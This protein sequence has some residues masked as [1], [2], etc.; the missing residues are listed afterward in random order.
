MPKRVAF[1]FVVYSAPIL[2]QAPS[3]HGDAFVMDGHIHLMTRQLLEGLDIGQ[4]YP[5]AILT[6]RAPARVD[7]TRCF[8]RL[9]AGALPGHPFP[10]LAHRQLV[11]EPTGNPVRRE[12]EPH[13]AFAFPVVGILG[14]LTAL[15]VADVARYLVGKLVQEPPHHLP[16]HVEG[17][18]VIR[19]AATVGEDAPSISG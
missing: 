10:A 5:T 9:Y 1:L 14:S 7:S 8:F 12:A 17:E 3:L 16:L 6:C 2:C 4:R 11:N 13:A 19:M 18:R 15:E